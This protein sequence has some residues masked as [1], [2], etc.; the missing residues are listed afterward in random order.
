M[1]SFTNKQD[2]RAQSV[3]DSMSIIESK[4]KKVVKTSEKRTVKFFYL[5]T[6][7]KHGEPS[8]VQ[9][10]LS[11][12]WLTTLKKHGNL[13]ESYLVLYENNKVI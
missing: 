8:Y 12:P 6:T 7:S 13:R 1:A 2:I 5:C 10:I 11:E 3:T 9:S 4:A